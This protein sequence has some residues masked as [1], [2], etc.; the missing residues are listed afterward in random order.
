MLRFLTASALSIGSVGASAAANIDIPRVL[1]GCNQESG[2]TWI[3]MGYRDVPQSPNESPY[4]TFS[5]EFLGVNLDNAYVL[6]STA[7]G[8]VGNDL[9]ITDYK[10]YYDNDVN[11]NPTPDKP[12]PTRRYQ[13]A[14]EDIKD[15]RGNVIGKKVTWAFTLAPDAFISNWQISYILLLT[16]KSSECK[17]TPPQSV[18]SSPPRVKTKKSAR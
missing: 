6:V 8:T 18:R 4:Y 2:F 16:N 13:A 15:P 14:I 3:A 5:R 10:L 9:R 11:N 17:V 1:M 7:T 12:N